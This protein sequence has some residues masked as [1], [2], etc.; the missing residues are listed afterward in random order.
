MG[1][2]DEVFGSPEEFDTKEEKQVER[3]PGLFDM[4]NDISN[5]GMVVRRWLK[6]HG[7]LPSTYNGFIIA[8]AFSN[9]FDTV[10]WAN[11]WNI[12][13]EMP[14]VAQYYLFSGAIKPRKRF[15]KWYKPVKD[16]VVAHLAELF[17]FTVKEMKQCMDNVPKELVDELETKI[18]NQTKNETIK[19]GRRKK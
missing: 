2:R 19:S 17:G 7:K 12:R 3:E 9:Y 8:K 18:Q 15:G 1:W 4:V 5:G 13:S 14:D 16:E 10:L 6:E 11:E